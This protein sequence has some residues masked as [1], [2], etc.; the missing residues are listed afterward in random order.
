MAVEDLVDDF[1]RD[2]LRSN[3]TGAQAQA[4]WNAFIYGLKDRVGHFPQEAQDEVFLRAAN[5]NAE[6]IAIARASL[7][8]LRVRLG[9]PAASNRLADVAAETLVRA[10]VWQGV[11]AFFR[12]FR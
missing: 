12:L 10:T 2:A 4:K 5:R 8:A 1:W 3:A 7:D 9:V 6:C 11:G